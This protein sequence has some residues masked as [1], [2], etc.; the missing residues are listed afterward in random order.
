MTRDLGWWTRL[1][2]T[3]DAKDTRGFTT[4]LADDC[5][6]RFAN[7]PSVVGHDAIGGAVDAF[8]SSIRASEHH[9]TDCWSGAASAVCEGTCTYTRHDG[10]T[11]TLPFAD[12]LHF[13]GDKVERYFIYM[14]VTPLYAGT[15][16]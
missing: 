3:I 4:Y 11:I 15:S 13:R 12:V 14:D 9:V 5:E 7:G 8:W 1:C 16:A 2:A 10:S 6:F